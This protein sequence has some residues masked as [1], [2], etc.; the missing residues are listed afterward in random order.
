MRTGEDIWNI[1]DKFLIFLIYKEHLQ[2]IKKNKYPGSLKMGKFK[3]NS[4]KN[5][6]K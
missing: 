4:V 6:D 1:Y 5:R 2:L 3:S